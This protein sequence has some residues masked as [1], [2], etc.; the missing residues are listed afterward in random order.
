MDRNRSYRLE[1]TTLISGGAVHGRYDLQ[2]FGALRFAANGRFER[3]DSVGR[4]SE[5]SGSYKDIDERHDLGAR[6]GS[7]RLSR[8]GGIASSSPT[9]SL[10]RSA[11]SPTTAGS[12]RRAA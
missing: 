10:N 3:F 6:S 5:G 1:G 9:T 4:I 11:I 7:S 2:D 12:S 8:N